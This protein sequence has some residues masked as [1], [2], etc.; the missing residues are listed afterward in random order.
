MTSNLPRWIAILTLALPCL[1]RAQ[2]TDDSLYRQLGE[3]PGLVALVDELVTDL[4]ADPRT[5]PFFR[6]I[7]RSHFKKQLVDQ[8]CEVSGGPCKLVGPDMKKAHASI[9]VAKRDFNAVVEVLQRSMDTRGIPFSTQNRLL[10]RL[11]P[12]H[13]DIVNVP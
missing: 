7:D 3:Q 2:A 1:T 8:L 4:L 6:D 10:A 9:D 11:A 13:R 5:N 12:M